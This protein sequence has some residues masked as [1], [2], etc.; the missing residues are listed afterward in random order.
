MSYAVSCCSEAGCNKFFC[1]EHLENLR[2]SCENCE[3]NADAGVRMGAYNYGG[4]S[5]LCEQHKPTKCRGIVPD[6]DPDKDSVDYPI[7]FEKVG[8]KCGLLCC[9]ECMGDHNCG[10]LDPA[11]YL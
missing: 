2:W 1:D 6:S 5:Y 3:Q 10:E 7:D 8:K 9:S 4:T 11:E